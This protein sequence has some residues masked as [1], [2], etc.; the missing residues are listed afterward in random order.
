[1]ITTILSC[2]ATQQAADCLAT[3]C[4]RPQRAALKT[5]QHSVISAMEDL[6]RRK[7]RWKLRSESKTKLKLC[8]KRLS[9]KARPTYNDKRLV[10]Y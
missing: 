9:L 3:N 10:C 6:G 8:R 7:N 4:L 5:C 2:V 1:M